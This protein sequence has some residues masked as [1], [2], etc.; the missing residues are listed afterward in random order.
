[1]RTTAA[2]VLVVLAL[3]ASALA[4]GGLRPGRGVAGATL[5]ATLVVPSEREGRDNAGIALS[6]PPG[7]EPV[8]CR[9]PV[10]WTC[11]ADDRGFAWQRLTGVVEA[12]DFELTLTVAGTP[13]T[14]TFPLAQTYDDGV[15][16]TFA[17]APG[18]RDEAPVFTVTGATAAS[19]SPAA[20]SPRTSSAPTRSLR[21]SPSV[22]AVPS[23]PGASRTAT[24]APAPTGSAPPVAS[25][26]S[27]AAE[28]AQLPPGRRLEPPSGGGRSTVPIALLVVAGTALA[29]TVLVVRRR[30]GDDA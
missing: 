1:M 24:A 15:T 10:G 23:A 25:A 27:A 12:R 28:L 11:S 29:G 20:A 2:A 7:F 4:H 8:D 16:N 17:G 22:A 19:R 18:S 6:V 9:P 21:P 26:P 13:G 3:P 5:E 14:Y 30:R